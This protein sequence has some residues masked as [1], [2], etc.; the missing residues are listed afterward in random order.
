[1]LKAAKELVY[2]PLKPAATLAFSQKLVEIPRVCETDKM[3]E[4]EN[5]ALVEIAIKNLGMQTDARFKET[6]N[7][8]KAELISFKSRILS[9]EILR[10]E[11]IRITTRLNKA[12]QEAAKY[13]LPC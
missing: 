4:A 6:V 9:L 13:K 8:I 2:H 12:C 10:S 7:E 11:F 3:S 1:L 5:K